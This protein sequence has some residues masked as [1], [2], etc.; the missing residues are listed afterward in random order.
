MAA[1]LLAYVPGMTGQFVWDDDSWTTSIPRLLRDVS[2][3]GLMWSQPTALQQYYPLTGTTF[4][5]DYQLWDFWT[6]PYH[7]ENVLLHASAALLFWSLLRRLQVPGAKLAAAI[8]ALHPL[9]VESAGWITERKNVLSLVL[10]LGAVLAYGKFTAYWR[11]DGE[12]AGTANRSAN[13]RRGA[14]LLAWVLLLA[15][16]LAKT[17]AFSLPPALL[18]IC[19]WKRG[20][21][22]WRAD[23]LP[24][25]PFFA[26]AIGLGLV[27]TWLEKHHVGAQGP[28]WAFTWPARCLIAGRALWFYTG[29]LLWPAHLCFIYPRW[30]LDAGSLVQWLYP[31]SAVGTLL[32]LWLA[33]G[34]IGRG[35]LTAALFFVGALFPLLGFVNG[36]FMRFSF[37]CDHWAYFSSLGL[38]ALAAAA[39]ARLGERLVAPR[40]VQGCAL[41]AL[42]LLGA[43]T[44]QQSKLYRDK[45]TLWSKTIEQNP[46]AYLARG[47]LGYVLLQQGRVDEALAQ[48][49][50]ALEILPGSP[51]ALNDVGIALLHKGQVP[52]A[53][54]RFQDALAANANFIDAHDNLGQALLQLGRV[55]EAVAHFQKALEIDPADPIANSNLGNIL[56]QTGRVD[57][58]IACIQKALEIE[59]ADPIANNNLGIAL[60]QKGRVDEAIIHLQKALA[61]D[62]TFADAHDALGQALLQK[63]RVDEAVAH[64]RRALEIQPSYVMAQIDLG[65]AAWMLATSPQESVRNGT[66]AVELAQQLDRLAGGRNPMIIRALAAA[67]AEAG[68]FPEAIAA[69][70]RALQMAGAQANTALV[71][72]LQAQIG[73]YQ[74]SC[75][76]R[77]T[78]QA[79]APPSTVKP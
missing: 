19:W 24:V 61:A 6:L 37:V 71:T 5:L 1:T 75:P 21:L 55:N 18:L 43:L 52:L 16:L 58:A 49:Q 22:R 38:I 15:A 28:E 12:P 56:L 36:Y 69:A 77:D 41:L 35:P 67:Y 32:A 31:I 62:A 8:F 59:P 66:K 7:V 73:L 39:V 54:A 78:G 72:E 4:W 14:W 44:W 50:K 23:V 63:G 45:E 51:N 20:R 53:M 11:E 34:R 40:A 3:L 30:Q 33:R 79:A 2:G 57:E 65:R 29:K 27:T 10:Y 47:S 48:F 9:M 60:L 46:G 70:Q 25:L 13:S 74:A 42:A 17:M 68:R 64:F 26:L 76:L